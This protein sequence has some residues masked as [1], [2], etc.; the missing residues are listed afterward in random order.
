[1][2]K[3]FNLEMPLIS[4]D[5]A[6]NVI[7]VL[8]KNN[9]ECTFTDKTLRFEMPDDTTDNTICIIGVMIGVNLCRF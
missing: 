4:D 1:M 3:P 8:K 7:E 2:A 5:Q 9:I 6:L